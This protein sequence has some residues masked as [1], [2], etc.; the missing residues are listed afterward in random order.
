MAEI[1]YREDARKV[2]DIEIESLKKSGMNWMIILTF[3][4]RRSWRAVAGLSLPAWGNRAILP[5][6]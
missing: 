2:F 3:L 1:D 5:G 4:F 6:K